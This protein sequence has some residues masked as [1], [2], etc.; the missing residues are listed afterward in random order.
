MNPPAQTPANHPIAA[1]LSLD[2]A[3]D[4]EV[5]GRKAASLARLAAA[6]LPVPPGVVLTTQVLRDAVARATVAGCGLDPATLAVPTDAADAL[7]AAV[8][9]WGD[10]PLAVRSSG[11]GEDGARASFA[12]LFETVLDVRG[13]DRLAAAVLTCWR[14]AF[15]VRVASYAGAHPP[16]GLAVLV[17]PMV[18]ATSAGVAFTADP[19]TGA[20]DRVLIDA[21]AGLGDRLVSGGVDPQRW[22]VPH[23]GPPTAVGDRTESALTPAQAV[24]IAALA[25]RVEA[26]HGAAQDVEW[27]LAGQDLVLL[28]ARPVTTTPG[29]VPG[30]PDVEPIPVP[31][32]VPPGFWA[33]EASHSSTPR[34]Q[35]SRQVHAQP[36]ASTRPRRGRARPAVPDLGPEGDR[37]L[38]VRADRARWAARSRPGCRSGRSGSPAGW[39]HRCGPGPARRRGQRG[40]TYR[41]S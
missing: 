34:R 35:L 31:V 2:A 1:V 27:A 41:G 37:W 24:R 39:C 13:A 26:L 19:V 28:Q 18:P 10:V 32:E 11:T 7:A 4:P 25:R 16:P 17:Q 21:V 5:V 14:S 6:G 15:A 22:T 40:R 29:V 9:G 20:R 36:D 38:G 23:A 12:G 33:R 3:L 8:R 30:R